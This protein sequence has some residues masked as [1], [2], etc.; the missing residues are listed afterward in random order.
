MP[1]Q[2]WHLMYDVRL[3]EMMDEEG[4]TAAA[5]YKIEALLESVVQGAVPEGVDDME[6]ACQAKGVIKERPP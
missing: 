3:V 5:P 6:G 1:W 4:F 2:W